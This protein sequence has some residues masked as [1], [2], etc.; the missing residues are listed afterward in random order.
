MGSWN[1]VYTWLEDAN[2][3]FSNDPGIHLVSAL[4]I[5]IVKRRLHMVQKQINM[6][7]DLKDQPGVGTGPSRRLPEEIARHLA[8]FERSAVAS[9]DS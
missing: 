4:S 8:R 6:V 2:G 9:K 5:K 3:R 7:T 1:V